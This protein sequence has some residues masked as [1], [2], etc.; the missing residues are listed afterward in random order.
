MSLDDMEKDAEAMGAPTDEQLKTIATLATKQLHKEQQLINLGEKVKELSA[1]LRTIVEVDLPTAMS[2]IGMDS[3][4]LDSGER[5]SI[6]RGH[7]ASITKK[8]ESEAHT[9]LRENGHGD[10]IKNTITGIF[11]K[12]QD[13]QADEAVKKLDEAGAVKVSRKEGVHSGTLKAFVKEQLEKG[14]NLPFKLLGIYPWQKS[15]IQVK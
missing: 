1:E 12:D 2:Q 8:N 13:K 4:T 15:K 7:A 6:E 10:I 5:I 11:G 3:F 14:I 9:W